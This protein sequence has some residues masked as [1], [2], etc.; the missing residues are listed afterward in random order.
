MTALASDPA[1]PRRGAPPPR[2]LW[3]CPHRTARY[4]EVNAL[5]RCG[6]EVIPSAGESADFP[7]PVRSHDAIDTYTPP[8]RSSCTVPSE[9][10][11]LIR[12]FNQYLRA[13][14]L[15]T[16]VLSAL[17]RW[18]DVVW[19]GTY[20]RSVAGLLRHFRGGV[21]LRAYGGYPYTA[22]L[23]RWPAR[24]RSLNLL[25]SSDRYV[26]CPALPYQGRIE[27]VRLT[28]NET[29]IPG[30]VTPER[31]RHRWTA[32]RSEPVACEVISLIGRY[33]SQ[34]YREFIDT[35][36]ALP[37]RVLGQNPPGG[38]DGRDPRIVGTLE[39][40][41]FHRAIASSRV[42]IYGGL[43][44]RY[45][46]HYHPIEAMMMDVPVAFL[47]SSALA[48][49]AIYLG[50]TPEELRHAGMCD[51][52]A[53]I[54]ELVR[55]ML[56][57]PAHAS[58]ISEGQEIMRRIYRPDRWDPVFAAVLL[59]ASGDRMYRRS[60]EQLA[61]DSRPFG[62]PGDG[63]EIRPIISSLGRALARRLPLLWRR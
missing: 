48:Q 60:N 63:F 1:S 25:A 13:D 3:V 19:V 26:F 29:F 32:A 44:S 36:G 4:E 56:S 46:L 24:S 34:V 15:P 30:C 20:S 17:D 18:I 49:T 28:R 23:G 35:Y 47:R 8:W 55:A 40:D 11:E 62:S 22:S 38:E 52:P 21:V 12:P 2:V 53:E 42:M 10:L 14:R 5:L 45:H 39:D 16:A 37:V 41:A 61:G 58:S 33:R 31:L 59:R 54:R 43:G 50:A 9:V 6:A 57:D 51:S 7:N 27:D